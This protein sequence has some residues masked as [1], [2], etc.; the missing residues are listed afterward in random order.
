MARPAEVGRLVEQFA[1]QRDQYRSGRYTEAQLRQDPL[2][3]FF[4]ALGWDDL[5][6][7]FLPEAVGY[8]RR[9]L[10]A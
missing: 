6:G 8:R 5:S 4:E 9:R 2:N 10:R 7:L 3:P 1:E